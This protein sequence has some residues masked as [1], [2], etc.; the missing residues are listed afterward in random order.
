LTNWIL[1]NTDLKDSSDIPS[2]VGAAHAYDTVYLLAS[3]IN[4]SKTTNPQK[5]RDALEKLPAFN[6]AVRD[7]SKPFTEQRHDALDK[8]QVLF[9]KLTPTGRLIPQD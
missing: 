9:V 7:Y 4:I 1:K 5:I 6:G 2:P 8:S 3:A